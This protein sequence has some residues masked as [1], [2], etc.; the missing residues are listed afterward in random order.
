MNSLKQTRMLCKEMKEDEL[1][2]DMLNKQIRKVIND[3]AKNTP[4]EN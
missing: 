4:C 3:I 2:Q 1:F